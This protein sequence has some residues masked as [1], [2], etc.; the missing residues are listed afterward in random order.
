ME[1]YPETLSVLERKNNRTVEILSL[2]ECDGD[3]CC[4]AAIVHE[5]AYNVAIDFDLVYCENMKILLDEVLLKVD[6]VIYISATLGDYAKDFVRQV[7]ILIDAGTY[8][9]IH[10]AFKVDFKNGNKPPSPSPDLKWHHEKCPSASQEPNGEELTLGAFQLLFPLCFSTFATTL[11]LLCYF[12]KKMVGVVVQAK[13][14]NEFSENEEDLALHRTIQA[15]SASNIAKELKSSGVDRDQL[16]AAVD[17]L[18]DKAPLVDLMFQS[19]CSV[20]LT[21]NLGW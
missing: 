19:C 16:S 7:N 3:D 13:V 6:N 17:S 8:S 18:P 9:E 5:D 15:M 10:Q 20:F 12:K 11:G 4:D 21:A 14:G 2:I 1:K